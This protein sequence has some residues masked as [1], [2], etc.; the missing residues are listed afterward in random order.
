M[1][2]LLFVF[3]CC[4]ACWC[5]ASLILFVRGVI[6]QQCIFVCICVIRVEQRPTHEAVEAMSSVL[7]HAFQRKTKSKQKRSDAHLELRA[8]NASMQLGV[9]WITS[10]IQ[11]VDPMCCIRRCGR[12]SFGCACPEIAVVECCCAFVLDNACGGM[13][14]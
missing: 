3:L 11:I 6:V 9:Q 4:L 8:Q 1:I 2:D 10:S 7:C 14:L 12:A 13:F 5:C